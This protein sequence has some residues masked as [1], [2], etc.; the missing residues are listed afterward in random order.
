MN[1]DEINAFKALLTPENLESFELVDDNG[2]TVDSA[3][4][5]VFAGVADQG[6]IDEERTETNFI[7]RPMTAE[8]ARIKYLETENSILSDALAELA[9]VVAG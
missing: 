5:F 7:L 1:E 9:E 6:M 3:T 2:T 8:E 4:G